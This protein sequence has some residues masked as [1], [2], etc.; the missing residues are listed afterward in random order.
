MMNDEVPEVRHN[1]TTSLMKLT[2]LFEVD[3]GQLQIILGNLHNK[4]LR[5]RNAV[6]A[7]LSAARL[8]NVRCLEAAV[9]ALLSNLQANP[10]DFVLVAKTMGRL[11]ANHPVFAECLI[12]S[13]L[14]RTDREAPLQPEPRVD[15]IF[16]VCK[17]V[18]YLNAVAH[19][20]ILL[21][22]LPPWAPSH[23]AVLRQKY[24]GLVPENEIVD[25]G[26]GIYT[27]NRAAS[28]ASTSG[29]EGG[30][31]APW[32]AAGIAATEGILASLERLKAATP[33]AR[34]AQIAARLKILNNLSKSAEGASGWVKYLEVY[35]ACLSVVSRLQEYGCSIG[36]KLVGET[37][38]IANVDLD[39]RDSAH[40]YLLKLLGYLRH[41]FLGQDRTHRLSLLELKAFTVALQGSSVAGRTE[42]VEAVEGVLE[43][44]RA[45]CGAAG[46][47]LPASLAALGDAKG[48]HGEGEE[49]PS[50]LKKFCMAFWPE[51]CPGHSQMRLCTAAIV[52]PVTS[53][54]RPIPYTPG[55]PLSVPLEIALA[56]ATP[57]LERLVVRVKE[58]TGR[59]AFHVRPASPFVTPTSVADAHLFCEVTILIHA[60]SRQSVLELD[61]ELRVPG[62]TVA[63]GEGKHPLHLVSRDVRASRKQR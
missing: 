26:R 54:S 50:E 56:N 47:A 49:L 63:I 53:A 5:M 24:P 40:A 18:L 4:S 11:G 39:P 17:M 58:R 16:Y 42:T 32:V 13:M 38:R 52:H 9:H 36:Q 23:S 51:S 60:S 3:F 59:A 46:R 2:D 8:G 45:L 12:D 22:L 15:D 33:A 48:R 25:V 7:L 19:N 1:A 28:V 30:P 55:F 14:Y 10:G 62:G 21:A 43:E 35:M 41:A 6:H 37:K 44:A 29:R 27:L 20:E 61:V 34:T 31:H 57:L